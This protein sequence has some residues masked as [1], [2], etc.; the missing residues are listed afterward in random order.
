MRTISLNQSTD[1]IN[2]PCLVLYVP[3]HPVPSHPAHSDEF[4]TLFG[5]RFDL[6]RATVHP[7]FG[8]VGD[9]VDTKWVKQDYIEMARVEGGA[10]ASMSLGSQVTEV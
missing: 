1:A 7:D 9:M 4:W 5:D 3:I 6:S 8:R 2:P 10:R